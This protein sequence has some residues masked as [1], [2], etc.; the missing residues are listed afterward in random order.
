MM[1]KKIKIYFGRLFFMLKSE[2]FNAIKGMVET[3]KPDNKI[4]TPYKNHLFS[5]G[6]AP[7]LRLHSNK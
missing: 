3:I 7:N 5:K 2:N 4:A 6:F 1:A